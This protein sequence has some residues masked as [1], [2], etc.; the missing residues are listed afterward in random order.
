MSDLDRRLRALAADVEWPD[1]P[2]LSSLVVSRLPARPRRR[3]SFRPRRLAIAVAL[4][5]LVPAA[6][7]VAFPSAR[8]DVLEW[9]GVKGAAVERVERLPP[10][11]DLRVAD[12]GRRVSL[13]EAERLAGRRVALPRVLPPP[14]QVRFDDRSGIVV[15]V[16]GDVLVFQG[17]GALERVHFRKLVTPQTQVREVGVDGSP[18]IYIAGAAHAV[19]IGRPDGSQSEAR[20]ASDTLIWS[21]GDTILRIEAERLPLGRALEIASSL[22]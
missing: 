7:A 13:E 22:R 16:H 3:G 1:T 12:L 2:D 18:G 5:V 17:R 20:L 19:L 9:L 6:G 14:E 11:E 4:A 15:T 10:A 21:R 8:D